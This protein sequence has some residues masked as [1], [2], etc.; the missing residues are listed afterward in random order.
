M[1][2]NKKGLAVF[3]ERSSGSQISWRVVVAWHVKLQL[4]DRGKNS[5]VSIV[6]RWLCYH[7]LSRFA[8]C[9]LGVRGAFAACGGA[10]GSKVGHGRRCWRN[11]CRPTGICRQWNCRFR[12]SRQTLGVA[13]ELEILVFNSGSRRR[14]APLKRGFTRTSLSAAHNHHSD[15]AHCR[16][17]NC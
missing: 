15:N 9:R 7:N 8:W 6:R 16:D 13:V 11:W 10:G 12:W 3:K 17:D 4:A 14:C 2:C 5:G 1:V